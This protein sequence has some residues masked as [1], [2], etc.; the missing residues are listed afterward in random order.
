M[1]DQ[2]RHP[3]AYQSGVDGEQQAA[4]FLI[5]Q[6]MTLVDRRVRLGTGEIDLVM[7]AGDMVVFV[8]VKFRPASA[9][10]SG[11]MAVHQ[12]KITRMLDCATRYLT[13]QGWLA[14]PI[15]FDVLEITRDG[16]I[17]VPN[18]FQG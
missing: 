18:A 11:L 12:G 5:Q 16:I 7:T 14:R 8:E 17:H 15:R 13:Q 9:A 2:V 6:G 3:T 10:G 4:D 1:K